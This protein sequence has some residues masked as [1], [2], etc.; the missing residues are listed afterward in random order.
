MPDQRT[1]S[2]DADYSEAHVLR[3]VGIEEPLVRIRDRY[4]L[5]RRIGSGGYGTVYEA[6]DHELERRVAIKVMD[7]GDPTAAQRE[8]QLLAKLEHHNVV[9]IF[10]HGIG[11]DYRYV[12]LQLLE[13]PTLREWCEKKSQPEVLAAFVQAGDGL[14]AAHAAGLVHRDFKPSNVRM[15][16]RDEA[17]V[18]D[19]GLARHLDTLDTDGEDRRYLA[20]TLAYVAPERLLGAAG[21]ARSDQ[22]SFCVA[23]WECLAGENPYGP[24]TPA[25]SAADRCRAIGRGIRRPRAIVGL[26]RDQVAAIKRG[27]EVRP[28]DRW[29]SMPALLRALGPREDHGRWIDIAAAGTALTAVG[30]VLAVLLPASTR[31]PSTASTVVDE[32]ELVTAGD[33]IVESAEAGRT[34]H[35][36]RELE[37]VTQ[38]DLDNDRARRLAQSAQSV[39]RTLESRGEWDDA[40]IAWALSV[41]LARTAGDLELEQ[42][43]HDRLYEAASSAYN[44]SASKHSTVP[45]STLTPSLHQ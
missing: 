14:A 3:A 28:D 43:G 27:L 42:I 21:D 26:R 20:G 30:L 23:L 4:E 41:R 29:P 22:F 15:G 18:V 32:F 17:V 11:D 12:V 24:A 35:A 5:A 40:V 31:G 9:R 2:I 1:R 10:D 45:S 16:P 36:L 44:G 37:R 38:R 6:I 7:L 33:R 19:F 8:G 25:M 13:G 39:A 34:E